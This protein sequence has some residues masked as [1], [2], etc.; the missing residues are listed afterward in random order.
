MDFAYTPDQEAL[1]KEVR[2]F[3]A[4]NVTEDLVCRTPLPDGVLRVSLPR[5]G[6]RCPEP[7]HQADQAGAG[8]GHIALSPS[9]SGGRACGYARP[10]V[11]RQS[12]LWNRSLRTLR[13][14][15]YGH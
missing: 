9:Q 10:F 13:A 14:Y 3:I 11:R 6:F 1:R 12:G 8:G 2:A 4:E 15:R 7:A 5:P